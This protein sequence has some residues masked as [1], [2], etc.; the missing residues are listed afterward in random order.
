MAGSTYIVLYD[1]DRVVGNVLGMWLRS[2]SDNVATYAADGKL[3]V[4]G[5]DVVV[6]LDDSKVAA[7]SQAN[8]TAFS[9][10]CEPMVLEVEFNGPMGAPSDVVE[11]GEGDRDPDPQYEYQSVP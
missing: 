2:T 7:F 6:G 10:L 9:T 8:P 1:N 4:D 5:V 3:T 11:R